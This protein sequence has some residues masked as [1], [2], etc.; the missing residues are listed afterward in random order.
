M[1]FDIK[2]YCRACERC[3]ISKITPPK[4]ITSMG[5]LSA[6]EPLEC[7]TIDFSIL[8]KAQGLE[9]VGVNRWVF[10]V[11]YSCTDP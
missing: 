6:S 10:Q 7:I 1:Y 2:K 3:T 11:D 4:V 8:E 9:N 5:H